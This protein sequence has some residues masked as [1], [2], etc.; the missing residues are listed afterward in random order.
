M[1]H[2]STARP[3]LRRALLAALALSAALPW[4]AFAQ[5][6]Y[7]ERPI[8]LI[9]PFA[10]G[11]IADVTARAVAESMAKTLGQ[12]V[13]VDNRPSAGS[14]VA[15]Q[16]VAGAKPDGH[17]LLL[18]T[19][20]N[21]VSVGLFKK[22]PYDT[23]KDLVPVSTLGYF[24]LGVFV[25]GGSRFASLRDV[26]QYAK[27]HPGRLNVGT[28][29][30]GSTQHLAG[31]LFQSVA[32]IDMLAVPYKGS[33]AV[34]VAL[35]SGEI[36]VALEIVGPMVPQVT[37][38]AVR[39][40]AVTGDRPN[41]ALPSAPTVHQ[42]GLPGYNVASWNAIAAPAGTPAP[43]VE[44]LNQA[45]REALASPSVRS[46]LEPLG[47]RLQPSTPAEAQALVVNEI[48]RWG[49]VIR[50]AKIEPQ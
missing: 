36:D 35:R 28:I 39:L 38:G 30:V 25:S 23:V 44:R 40:L 4:A 14:I 15:S 26:L 50:A 47:V 41:P 32:G 3:S 5:G 11:G 24:D 19:N 27:E 31:R 6:R 17:T 9:V 12:P 29:A 46:R 49:D 43:V 13:V 8:T 45:V 1:T 42:A 33:P 10:P 20:S 34:L 48:K 21:A 2:P 7:P 37:S 18:M 22:L 16:A